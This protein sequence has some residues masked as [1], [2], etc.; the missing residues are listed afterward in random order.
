MRVRWRDSWKLNSSGRRVKLKPYFAA[1]LLEPRCLLTDGTAVG[2]PGIEVPDN[3]VVIDASQ[4][5]DDGLTL[6]QIDGMIHVFQT[7]TGVDVIDPI[8]ADQTTSIW[9]IGRDDAA[10]VLTIDISGGPAIPEAWDVWFGL[11]FLGGSGPQT[12]EM[13]F[14]EDSPYHVD[15]FAV[16]RAEQHNR[17]AMAAWP[18]WPN[19]GWE[20]W[21]EATFDDVELV[22][23][24]LQLGRHPEWPAESGVDFG[25]DNNVITIDQTD[26]AG[27]LVAVMDDTTNFTFIG[28]QPLVYVSAGLGDDQIIVRPNVTQPPVISG[29]LGSDTIIG[30]AEFSDSWNDGVYSDD[31]SWSRRQIIAVDTEYATR[32]DWATWI[33][34]G[35]AGPRST[36]GSVISVSPRGFMDSSAETELSPLLN[37]NTSSNLARLEDNSSLADANAE[38]LTESDETTD[39]DSQEPAEAEGFADFSVNMFDTELALPELS[40]LTGEELA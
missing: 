21:R 28:R 1:E 10:D 17:I 19:N 27:G 23:C 25:D 39:D 34:T 4:W 36:N 6:R 20:D 22:S 35:T 24:L 9:I 8:S 18:D 2:L 5:T 26:L 13:R 14:I 30:N 32:F 15:L 29:D 16:T 37:Q 33:S 7:D 38:L 40:P 3:A 11:H 12:D 31:G